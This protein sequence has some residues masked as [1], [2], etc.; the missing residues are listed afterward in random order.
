MAAFFGH[1]EIIMWYKDV[2]GFNDINPKNHKGNTPLYLATIEGHIDVV[3][4]Y[5]ENDH[6]T[7]SNGF[8]RFLKVY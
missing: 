7:S 3:N 6:Q 5:I 1:L 8:K 2:L 4:Y